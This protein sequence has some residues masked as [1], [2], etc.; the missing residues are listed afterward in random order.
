VDD[1]DG[2]E[3]PDEETASTEEPP[4]LVL[5]PVLVTA[6]CAPPEL[7]I[8]TPPAPPVEPANG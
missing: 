4:V 3:V 1:D 7:D 5:K 8:D 2:E 6:T